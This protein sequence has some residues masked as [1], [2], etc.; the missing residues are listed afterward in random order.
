MTAEAN[1]ATTANTVELDSSAQQWLNA[2]RTAK[3]RLAS[4]QEL[5]DRCRE[6]LEAILGDAEVATVDA[7]PVIRFTT[8]HST[9]L[10]TSKLKE[11][12]PDIYEQF[13]RPQITR[14]FTIV[15][16]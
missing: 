16:S 2:Y 5:V 12:L 6:Q 4:D 14:R 7:K 3:E 1:A 15:D 8:V 13:T 11:N 10:D 9:R